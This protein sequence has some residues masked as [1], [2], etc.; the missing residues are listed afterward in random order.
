[1]GY[2]FGKEVFSAFCQKNNLHLIFRGHQ[3]FQD[4]ICKFFNDRFISFFSAHEYG[5][6]KIKAKYI[7]LNASNIHNYQVHDIQM[8]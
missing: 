7:E 6:S 4:G 1:M 2:K 5:K 3:V 8:D